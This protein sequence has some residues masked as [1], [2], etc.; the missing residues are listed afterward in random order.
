MHR[1]SDFYG[2]NLLVE[3]KG[4]E[5]GYEVE[6]KQTWHGAEFPFPSLPLPI[7]KRSSLEAPHL[8]CA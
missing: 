2:V 1:N 4:N 6:V 7:A 5:F 8:F 3:G